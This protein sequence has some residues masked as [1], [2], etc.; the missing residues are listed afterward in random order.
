MKRYT[1]LRISYVVTD[2]VYARHCN[3]SIC[4][5]VRNV[6]MECFE[7]LGHTRMDATFFSG[8]WSFRYAIKKSRVLE[9]YSS[10]LQLWRYQTLVMGS[11]FISFSLFIDYRLLH[12]YVI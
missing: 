12:Y 7:R 8:D 4:A 5:V 10:R 1:I 3:A 6:Q 9:N 2:K 11:T